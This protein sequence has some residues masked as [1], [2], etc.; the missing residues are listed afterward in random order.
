MPRKA[1]A[2]AEVPVSLIFAFPYFLALFPQGDGLFG[3][4]FFFPYIK[5]DEMVGWHYQLNGHKFE[6][7]LGNGEGQGSPACCSPWDDKESDITK[8]LNT[9]SF[10]A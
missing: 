2:S 6:Q 4:F 3:A 9:N 7:T 1:I 5:L 10:F 8:R